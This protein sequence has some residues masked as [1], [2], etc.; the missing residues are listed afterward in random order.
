M[1]RLP[2][3]FAVPREIPALPSACAHGRE[4]GRKIRR[5]TR[6]SALQHF[7]AGKHRSRSGRRQIKART[8]GGDEENR[9]AI[10]G[11]PG[12]KDASSLPR[13]ERGTEAGKSAKKRVRPRQTDDILS[14]VSI[15]IGF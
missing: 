12:G 10:G 1:V 2:S 9:R 11:M 13:H 15:L 3:R 4:W 14:L 6:P 7:R 5:V 8:P